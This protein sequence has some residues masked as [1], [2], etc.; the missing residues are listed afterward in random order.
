MLSKPKYMLPGNLSQGAPVLE[1]DENGNYNFSFALDGDEIINNATLNVYPLNTNKMAEKDLQLDFLNLTGELKDYSIYFQGNNI[2]IDLVVNL[3]AFEQEIEFISLDPEVKSFTSVI[4]LKF[5]NTFGDLKAIFTFNEVEYYSPQALIVPLLIGGTMLDDTSNDFFNIG[6][7]GIFEDF[8]SKEIPCIIE[9]I[10]ADKYKLSVLEQQ[11]IFTATESQATINDFCYGSETALEII[12]GLYKINNNLSLSSTN[13]VFQGKKKRFYEGGTFKTNSSF[14]NSKYSDVTKIILPVKNKR[15]EE[16]EKRVKLNIELSGEPFSNEETG[17]LNFLDFCFKV[18]DEEEDSYLDSK[19]AIDLDNQHYYA[20]MDSGDAW[21]ELRLNNNYFK[22]VQYT[23]T[24]KLSEA[25]SSLLYKEEK[26][27]I[28][29]YPKNEIGKYN[30]V[31]FIV[32]SNNLKLTKGK[33]YFW[34]INIRDKEKKEIASESQLFYVKDK[35]SN[36]KIYQDER[37]ILCGVKSYQDDSDI[38][39]SFIDYDIIEYQYEIKNKKGITYYKSPLIKSSNM[40]FMNLPLPLSIQN[41]SSRYSLYFTAL[42]KDMKIIRLTEELPLSVLNPAFD[43]IY[44][45]NILTKEI[46]V[47]LE[48]NSW[49]LSSYI[50][51]YTL[52]C[53]DEAKENYR[54]VKENISLEEIRN[55][56]YYDIFNPYQKFYYFLVPV[57][58]TWPSAMGSPYPQ[59][60]NFFY[61]ENLPIDKWRLILTKEK[62]SDIIYSIDKVYDFY[63]NLISGSIG[64][65]AETT[66]NTNFTNMPSVQKGFSNYWSGSLSALMGVCDKQGEFAQTIEQE[67][68]LE[69]LIL[70]QDHDKFLLDREGNIWQVEI[71]APLTIANQDGLIQIDKLIDLKTIT[72][73][74]VQVGSPTQIIFDFEE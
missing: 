18:K 20:G 54:I 49:E 73:N 47:K 17:E 57:I 11:T 35:T 7:F 34:T 72:I 74:W 48:T 65:N 66:I 38:V 43:A 71:S 67:K 37:G 22:K 23:A 3:N 50:Q 40:Q 24:I 44:N 6:P 41:D 33:E 53:C 26:E 63:Y 56:S 32:N 62:K 68:A 5:K 4:K 45:Y 36:L 14:G 1:P 10:S 51:N 55:F 42:N 39:G 30:F 70:D 19:F 12:G 16:V 15:D 9:K 69:Q 25:S 58:K 29:F 28:D 13:L 64:N 61:F 46:N 52:M 59:H 2:R 8:T 21:L 60:S 27:N 31:K